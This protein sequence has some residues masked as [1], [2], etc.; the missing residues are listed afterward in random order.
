MPD[1]SRLRRSDYATLVVRSESPALLASGADVSTEKGRKAV[2]YGHR[3]EDLPS[4]PARRAVPCCWVRV[5]SDRIPRDRR[6][7]RQLERRDG[8]P[9]TSG[10]LIAPAEEPP[11]PGVGDRRG[12]YRCGCGHVLRVFG[13]GRHRVYF[14]PG[15][16]KL[17]DPVMNGACPA[18]GR[19]LPGKNRS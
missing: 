10:T 18:C 8:H 14:E 2:G 13:G 5:R 16:T 3:D 4:Q 1:Q 7:R 19:G 17:D 11:V 12:E 6:Q 9:M 15:N